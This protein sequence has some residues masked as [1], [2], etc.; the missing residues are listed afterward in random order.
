MNPGPLGPELKFVCFAS[1][2]NVEYLLIYQ[3]F[4]CII[5]LKVE[6]CFSNFVDTF[7]DTFVDMIFH[8]MKGVTTW[9][10]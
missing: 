5:I 10:P 3:C 6:I 4:S 2:N 7:V 1:C 9:L 8:N